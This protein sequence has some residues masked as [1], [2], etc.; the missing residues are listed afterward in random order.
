MTTMSVDRVTVYGIHQSNNE[1]YNGPVTAWCSSKDIAETAAHKSGWYGG[2]APISTF[3]ALLINGAY[4]ILHERE[5]VDMNGWQRAK[6]EVLRKETLAGLS[7][8][9]IRVLGIKV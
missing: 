9:Q 8:E 5:P 4:W 2:D 1:K 7:P 6:D 3:S